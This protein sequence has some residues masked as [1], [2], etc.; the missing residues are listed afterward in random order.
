MAKFKNKKD[1]SEI[2]AILVGGGPAPGINGV[3][4]A[5]TIEA[6]NRGKTVIGI[7]DGFKWLARGDKNHIRNLTIEETSRI[8]LT[9]GSIIGTSRENPTK[10]PE[11][12]KNTIR[13]LKELNVKYLITIGGDDTMF[14]ASRVEAE[15]KGQIKVAHVPKTI[16]NDLPLPGYNPTFGF[17]TA[18]H[19]GTRLVQSL[20]EDAR[21]TG[22]WYFVV[23]MGRK[24]GHL[25]LGI[26]KSSGATLTII[27]EEFGG[28]KIPLDKLVSILEG[29]IIKR[30]SIGREDG[31]AILAEGLAEKL[32]ETE[33][34]DLKEV[35]RDEHGNIRFA[36][37]DLG[38]IIKKE[39][40]KRLLEKGIKITIVD[41]DI[42]YE[43]RS[44]PPIPFD[45]KYTRDLGYSAVKFLFQGGSGAMIS[46]QTGKMIPISFNEILDPET[47]RTRVRYVDINTESY[48]AAEKYMIKLKKED[49][50]DPEQ[51]EKLAR[52][53]HMTPEE[54]VNYF[55]KALRG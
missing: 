10:S 42:G 35:E 30:L 18:R 9:G 2:L 25:A 6:I 29:A 32:D 24:A 12:L 11:K 23:A 43:F 4:S 50:E 20:M 37:I 46:I 53:V 19:I 28:K 33:L 52:T 40:Q 7:V 13:T 41:K 38:K 5:A 55:S 31:V 16:D 3:I 27:P 47:G 22:R 26:G 8:H 51:I 54:F 1:S 17:E 21:T 44:A 48:E 34:E 15:S 36:E 14:S 49:F 45:A 39:T